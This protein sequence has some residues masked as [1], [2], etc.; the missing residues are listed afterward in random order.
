MSNRPVSGPQSRPG[1]PATEPDNLL[2]DNLFVA[3]G[4]VKDKRIEGEVGMIKDQSA[5]DG[6]ESKVEILA[7]SA[8]LGYDQVTIAGA[9][10]HVELS[11]EDSGIDLSGE[12]AGFKLNRGTQNAD[13][14]VGYNLGAQVT[15]AGIEGTKRFGSASSLTFGL[16]AGAGVEIS[17]GDRDFDKD[18]SPE[19]CARVSLGWA[20][21]GFCFEHG[22]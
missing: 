17:V 9:I 4:S 10:N 12:V 6:V 1:G 13:G 18:N 2:P 5:H 7:G 8:S 20:T 22:L 21:V 15:I 14:S 19:L 3:R 16:S 11:Y